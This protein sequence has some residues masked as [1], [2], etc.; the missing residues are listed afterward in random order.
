MKKSVDFFSLSFLA[1][2]YENLLILEHSVQKNLFKD[3]IC[4]IKEVHF[5]ELVKR[6]CHLFEKTNRS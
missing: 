6:I 3:F 4:R 1:R 2:S 5:S